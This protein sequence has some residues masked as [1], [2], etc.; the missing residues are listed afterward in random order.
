MH[1]FFDDLI[2]QLPT[3][4][5]PNIPAGPS[6]FWPEYDIL[7]ISTR[8]FVGKLIFGTILA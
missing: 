2:D 3:V 4:R 8:I 7:L 5:N 1:L 6:D